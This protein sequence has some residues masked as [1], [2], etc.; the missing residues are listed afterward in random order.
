M[1]TEKM[2]K[3]C[4]KIGENIPK[5]I[6]DMNPQIQESQ[7]ITN[8][9]IKRHTYTYHVE[10]QNDTFFK[11]QGKKRLPAKEWQTNKNRSQKTVK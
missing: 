1:R 10:L 2:K 9:I 11:Q 7:W 4:L 3:Y 6:E 8:R 5:L